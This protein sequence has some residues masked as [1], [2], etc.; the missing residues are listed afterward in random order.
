MEQKFVSISQPFSPQI[1]IYK[2]KFN[3]PVRERNTE[4]DGGEMDNEREIYME[5]YPC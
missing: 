3:A 4:M 5:I 1:G 2:S